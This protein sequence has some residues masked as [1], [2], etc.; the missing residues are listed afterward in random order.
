[1]DPWPYHYSFG[2]T[3]E[4]ITANNLQY[5]EEVIMYEGPDQ[6]AAMFIETRYEPTVFFLLQRDTFKDCVNS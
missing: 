4:E 5:L 6:I 2:K 1:M 3:E